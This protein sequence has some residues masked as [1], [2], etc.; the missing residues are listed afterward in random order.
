MTGKRLP[1]ALVLVAVLAMPA[2]AQVS[3]GGA[4]SLYIHPGG[5]PAGMG[6]AFVS[7][8]DDAVACWWNPAGLAFLENLDVLPR[9]HVMFFRRAVGAK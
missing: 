8:A 3:I 7:V 1:I 2:A 9:Q 4:Q 5:R 6:D